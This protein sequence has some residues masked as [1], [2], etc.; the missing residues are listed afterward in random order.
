M[1]L[2]TDEVVIQIT[3]THN[4]DRHRIGKQ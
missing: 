1:I 2:K 3:N 4:F